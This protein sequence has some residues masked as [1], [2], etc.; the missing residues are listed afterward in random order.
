MSIGHY[1]EYPPPRYHRTP[2]VL[3]GYSNEV[4]VLA[5]QSHFDC[6]TLFLC[7][8]SEVNLERMRGIVAFV[9]NQKNGALM[10]VRGFDTYA[11]GEEGMELV[12]FIEILREGRIVCLAV[13]VK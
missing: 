12:K 4:A 11:S 2:M 5:S 6:Y 3:D 8:V 10:A 9:L 7:K 1:R 13:K